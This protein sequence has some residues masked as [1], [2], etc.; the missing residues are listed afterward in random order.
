MDSGNIR[1]MFKAVILTCKVMT[2]VSLCINKC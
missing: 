2:L 1:K